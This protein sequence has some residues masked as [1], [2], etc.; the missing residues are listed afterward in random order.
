MNTGNAVRK[1]A[2]ALGVKWNP[3]NA[4]KSIALVQSRLIHLLGGDQPS[5]IDVL[6]GADLSKKSVDAMSSRAEGQSQDD[7][8]MRVRLNAKTYAYQILELADILGV[9]VNVGDNVADIGNAVMA[10]ARHLADECNFS[11]PENDMDTEDAK[12]N[13]AETSDD[14]IDHVSFGTRSITNGTTGQPNGT[15]PDDVP[16]ASITDEL[17]EWASDRHC[18]GMS[19]TDALNIGLIADRI[20]E[21]FDRICQQQEAVLQSTIDGMVKEYEHDRLPDQLRIEKLVEQRD[22]ARQECADL[23]DLLRD[24][25]VDFEYA[26]YSWDYASIVSENITIETERNRL[27]KECDELQA[28]LNKANGENK[29][30][31][32][33]I[34]EQ[35]ESI[36]QRK[37]TIKKLTRDNE[38]VWKTVHELQAKLDAIRDALDG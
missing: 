25:V 20:D 30:L 37:K 14:E 18:K 5:G 8:L 33:S 3:D 6:R 21:Q 38:K 34:D 10:K 2:V 13:P 17:R 9:D 7:A 19:H 23:L 28:R 16:M 1:M 31:K 32:L 36:S 22:E 11:T 27:A 12:P 24:A 26:S 4:Q 15:C 35:K 29:G